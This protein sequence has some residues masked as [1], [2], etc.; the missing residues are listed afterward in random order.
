[1]KMSSSDS[2]SE[3]DYIKLASQ[4]KIDNNWQEQHLFILTRG[5][6]LQVTS[7]MR[8]KTNII[9]HKAIVISLIYK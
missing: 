1:M 9:L 2:V 6:D 8:A 7:N 3:S 5:D 4:L